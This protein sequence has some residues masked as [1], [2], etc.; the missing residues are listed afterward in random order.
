MDQEARTVARYGLEVDTDGVQKL[1]TP[2]KLGWFGP[3]VV[4]LQWLLPSGEAV[5]LEAAA[6]KWGLTAAQ[7]VRLLVRDFL[8]RG[9]LTA[10]YRPQ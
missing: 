6:H 9:E 8:G 7:L 5:A 4:E 2:P 3:G 10:A 1:G